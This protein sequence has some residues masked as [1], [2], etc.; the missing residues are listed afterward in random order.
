ML[1]SWN[2]LDAVELCLEMKGRQLLRKKE[3]AKG[4]QKTH[5]SFDPHLVIL[6]HSLICSPTS[7]NSSLHCLSPSHFLL[8]FC[9]NIVDCLCALMLKVPIERSDSRGRLNRAREKESE[10]GEGDD[11]GEGGRR[12]EEGGENFLLGGWHC[13]A[14]SGRLKRV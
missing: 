11:L 1:E 12:E 14:V 7:H 4:K 8:D 2:L 9:G 10:G 6:H 3:K 13:G 5:G